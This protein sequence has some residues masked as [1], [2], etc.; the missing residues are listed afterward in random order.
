MALPSWHP[1]SCSYPS[2]DLPAHGKVK[3]SD[4]QDGCAANLATFEQRQGYNSPAPPD[5]AAST[6]RKW[7]VDRMTLPQYIPMCKDEGAA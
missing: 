7:S 5:L 2:I 6:A 3:G 4:P 1:W